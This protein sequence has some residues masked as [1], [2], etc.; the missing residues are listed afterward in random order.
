MGINLRTLSLLRAI[1]ENNTWGGGGWG[2]RRQTIYFSMGG[3]CGH[4]SNNMGH[5][6]LKKSDYMGGGVLSEN[7]LLMFDRYIK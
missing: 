7:W 6:C 4:F 2:G 5:W 1:P 3:C